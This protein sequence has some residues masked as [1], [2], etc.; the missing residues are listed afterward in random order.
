MTFDELKEKFGVG[1]D[2]ESLESV[3]FYLVLCP[4]SE[5]EMLTDADQSIHTYRAGNSQY[6]M[7]RSEF[8]HKDYAKVE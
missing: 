4:K 8:S 7:V 3:F 1:T 2:S 6:L 5:T